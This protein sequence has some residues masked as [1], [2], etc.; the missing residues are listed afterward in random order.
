MAYSILG[1]AE[2]ARGD[3]NRSTGAAGLHLGLQRGHGVLV[4][5]EQAHLVGGGE[6]GLEVLGH[7]VALTQQKQW[8]VY[9]GMIGYRIVG[10]N[11][12]THHLTKA[13]KGV[14]VQPSRRSRKRPPRRR[15]KQSRRNHLHC[16]YLFMMG[17]IN[18]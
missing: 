2:R 4:D 11:E 7:L 5:V 15:G 17:Y 8:S 12:G 10:Q 9:S 16:R 18:S 1:G 6:L 13:N 14:V 3:A